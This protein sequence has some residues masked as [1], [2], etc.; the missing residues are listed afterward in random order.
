MS[1]D[2]IQRSINIGTG[3]GMTDI[4]MEN[5]NC[6]VIFFIRN[7]TGFGYYGFV[8]FRREHRKIIRDCVNEFL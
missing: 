2:L 6:A 3:L 8:R 1:C 7:V 4:L 5:A